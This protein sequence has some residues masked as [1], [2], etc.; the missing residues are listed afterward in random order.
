M[1]DSQLDRFL[2]GHEQRQRRQRRRA[3]GKTLAGGGG[4]IA[5]GVEFV[6][7]CANFGGWCDISA[8]PPALSEIGPK[9]SMVMVTPAVASIPTAAM[10]IPYWPAVWKATKMASTM[11][12]IGKRATFHPTARP[13][14]MLVAGPVFELG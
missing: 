2:V 7:D 3:D 12:R 6:G 14:M 4:G 10:A 9:A 1:T 11:I 5:D 13:V 8:M